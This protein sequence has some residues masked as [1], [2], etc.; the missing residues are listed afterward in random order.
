MFFDD[1][2]AP[3]FANSS[4]RDEFRFEFA[5]QR[6]NHEEV[7]IVDESVKEDDES[8]KEDITKPC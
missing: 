5:R 1:K 2:L 4:Q 8:V 3:R 6:F 7:F